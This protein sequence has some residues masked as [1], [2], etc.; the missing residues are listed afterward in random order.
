MTIS[1]LHQCAVTWLHAILQVCRRRG[2]IGLCSSPCLRGLVGVAV[3][4]SCSSFEGTSKAYSADAPSPVTCAIIDNDFDVDDMM[5]MP[6]VL[7]RRRVSAIIQTEGATL[8]GVSAPGVDALVN[9]GLS[10]PGKRHIPVIA[11]GQQNEGRDITKYQKW[12]P[13]FRGMMTRV[14]GLLPSPPEPWP[15]ERRFEDKLV[16][17]VEDCE[18]VS[19]LLLGPYTSFVRYYPRLQKKVDRIVIM[20]LMIGDESAG[21]GRLSFNCEYDL[22]A[23]EVAMVLL[24]QKP[25]FF[26]DVP[27][28][29]DC[30][31][32]V[33]P[34]P[35]HC[36]TPNLAMV[37]GDETSEGLVKKGLPGRLRKALLNDYDCSSLL[38]PDNSSKLKCSSQST[39]EP[40]ANVAAGG[41]GILL[42]D[43]TAA[44]FFLQPDDFAL[45]YPADNPA[46]GGKHYEPI[47][48]DASHEKTVDHLRARWTE[49]TNQSIQAR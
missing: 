9:F 34:P 3:L 11:A 24:K 5:A 12:L 42:W 49:L 25:A 37:A 47:V 26:V 31:G 30:R 44:L 19:I 1:S 14:N 13:F 41:S 36:Y 18:S 22:A 6:M 16:Q 35:P 48:I 4:L 39:W 46:T 20:G 32:K 29:P 43:Q 21:K 28:L 10:E 2:S 27:R 40:T 45:F 33:T 8:P 38:N 23:C 7:G 15:L 17:L